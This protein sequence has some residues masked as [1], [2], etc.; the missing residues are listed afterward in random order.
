MHALC[1]TGVGT[2]KRVGQI[3]KFSEASGIGAGQG[4]ALVSIYERR[5]L[6]LGTGSRWPF[7]H[8]LG[9]GRIS[10][11]ALGIYSWNGNGKSYRGQ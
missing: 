1:F 11:F 5:Q 2:K 3:Q 6:D 7:S 4:R 10:L 9:K 8:S